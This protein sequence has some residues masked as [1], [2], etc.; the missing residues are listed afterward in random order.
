M[1][2]ICSKKEVSNKIDICVSLTCSLPVGQLY[3]KKPNKNSD[4]LVSEGSLAVDEQQT[5]LV[6]HIHFQMG[7]VLPAG[8]GVRQTFRGFT[9]PTFASVTFCLLLTIWIEVHLS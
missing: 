5:M 9:L 3:R 1:L 2:S 7:L 8:L 4:D 6:Q